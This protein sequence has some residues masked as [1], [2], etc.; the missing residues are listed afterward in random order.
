LAIPAFGQDE[1]KV[2]I[3]KSIL[4][5]EQLSELNQKSLRAHVSGWAGVGKEIGEAVNSS[6]QAI[7]TQSNNFAQTSVG[8]LTVL[9][10]IWKVI[11]D[12]FLHIVIGLLELAIFLPI[13]IWSYQRTCITRSFKMPDKTVKVIEYAWKGEFSPRTIHMCLMFGIVA[14]FLVTTFSY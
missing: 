9:L 10:V 1:E 2:T 14:V 11:G 8:K 3:P 12:Q 5:K 13:W 7:T 6:L 4:T